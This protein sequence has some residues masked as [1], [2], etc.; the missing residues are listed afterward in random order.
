MLTIHRDPI[1]FSTAFISLCSK[2]H[3]TGVARTLS[4]TLYSNCNKHFHAWISITK[5]KTQKFLL[6]LLQ[7]KILQSCG[8][9]QACCTNVRHITTVYLMVTFRSRCTC[10]LFEQLKSSHSPSFTSAVVFGSRLQLLT[11]AKSFCGFSF[12]WSQCGTGNN[13]SVI[14]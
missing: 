14:P 2:W 4:P 13:L 6:K 11:A 5:K 9:K 8:S 10:L 3:Y 12:Y 7:S 1:W